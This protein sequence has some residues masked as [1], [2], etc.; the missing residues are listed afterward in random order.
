[1]VCGFHSVS[2]DH[3]AMDRP[4]MRATAVVE[5]AEGDVG[6]SPAADDGV[7]QARVRSTPFPP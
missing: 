6:L 1:M 4:T 5:K 2:Q 3:R 7:T